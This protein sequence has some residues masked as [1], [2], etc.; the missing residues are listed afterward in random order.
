MTET[1]FRS[2]VDWWLAAII[3]AGLLLP[4]MTIVRHGWSTT[5][6]L[7]EVFVIG[8]MLAVCWPVRYTIGES[9]L[10]VRSGL[11]RRYVA[12]TQI[13]TVRPTHNPLSAP[14]WSLDRLELELDGGGFLL[15][16]PVDKERF[17]AELAARAHLQRLD[18]GLARGAELHG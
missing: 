17:L 11:W 15:I 12:Y 9:E 5:A 13:K 4:V 2:K 18:S 10:L 8:L 7:A 1:S 14:A 16:S 6:A 3:V